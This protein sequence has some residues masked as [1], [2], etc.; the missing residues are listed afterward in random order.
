MDLLKTMYIV[1]LELSLV[2]NTQPPSSLERHKH[3]HLQSKNQSFIVLES[4]LKPTLIVFE[5]WIGRIKID[6]TCR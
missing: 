6:R 3:Q 4:S 1:F 5:L 2:K